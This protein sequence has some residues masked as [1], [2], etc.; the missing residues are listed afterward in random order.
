MLK[1]LFLSVICT[2]CVWPLLSASAQEPLSPEQAFRF[3]ARVVDAN[4]LEARWD[5]APGYYMYRDK[6]SFSVESGTL[7]KV[8][9]PPGQP[10]QDETFGRVETYRDGVAVRLPVSDVAGRLVL[11]A[12][13]QGCADIG[14]CYPPQKYEARLDLPTGAAAS[15]PSGA[16]PVSTDERPLWQQ[17]LL[18][19]TILWPAALGLLGVLLAAIPVR[20]RH[21]LLLKGTGFVVMMAGAMLLLLLNKEQ[22]EVPAE[23]PIHAAAVIF[24]PVRNITDLDAMLALSDKPVMLDFYADWCGPCRE[25]EKHTFSDAEVR[26]KLA[27]FTLLRADVTANTPEHQA[28]L[29]R[30]GLQGPPG[31]VFLDAQGRE[32]TALRIVGYRTPEAFLSTLNAAH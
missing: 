12:S 23:T 24:S 31:I 2:L 30:F 8:D 25:M 15:T 6:F 22:P 17:R 27:G 18:Q 19:P 10:K 13:A 1:R 14:I 28:L 7:G 29:K 21:P 11:R 32:R 3:S 26:A 4:T 16:A 9:L 20:V 5:I